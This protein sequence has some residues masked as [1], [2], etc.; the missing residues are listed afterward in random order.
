MQLEF[1]PNE[2]SKVMWPLSH[3]V[4]NWPFSDPNVIL[5][6]SISSNQLM[7]FWV[8]LGSNSRKF[9]GLQGRVLEFC[10]IQ[11]YIVKI[12]NFLKEAGFWLQ[13]DHFKIRGFD[14]LCCKIFFSLQ[15]FS[16]ST[17]SIHNWNKF[18]GFDPK[19]DKTIGI[20]RKFKIEK[21][22]F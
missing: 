12:L 11:R 2:L 5:W 6:H 1:T 15:N 20:N 7:I 21:L 10:N 9:N 17:F 4:Q 16:K 22:P 13:F 14:S 3:P 8:F 19:L 18:L